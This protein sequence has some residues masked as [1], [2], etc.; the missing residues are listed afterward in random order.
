MMT[1]KISAQYIAKRSSVKTYFSILWHLILNNG[2][3]KETMINE[4]VL[5]T[6]ARSQIELRA[7]VSPVITN[8][9]PKQLKL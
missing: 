7:L 1:T 6:A 4:G 8:I 5:Q 9:F 3:I 2:S